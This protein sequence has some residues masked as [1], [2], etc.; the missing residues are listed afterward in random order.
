[1]SIQDQLVNLAN[2]MRI[3]LIGSGTPETLEPLR[4]RV[5]PDLPE[6]QLDQILEYDLDLEATL[7]PLT[8]VSK[9]VRFNDQ[10]P[11]L[12]DA[13][14]KTFADLGDD[15]NV[16][17]GIPISTPITGG[18]L[19]TDG[20]P[21]V[22]AQL[23][24]MLAKLSGKIPILSS[25]KLPVA[26][27]VKWF[28]AENADGTGPLTPGQDYL[29]PEGLDG[30]SA[31]ILFLPKLSDQPAA[32]VSRWLFAKVKL[33]AGAFSLPED[34]PEIRLPGIEVKVPNLPLTPLLA[35]RF[36]IQVPVPTLAPAE[37]A[38]PEL[39]ETQV[40]NTFTRLQ[41]LLPDLK[42][43]LEYTLTKGNAA[44]ATG[45]VVDA[46]GNDF[47]ASGAWTPGTLLK[48]F[49][50]PQI[51][52][53][54]ET[55]SPTEWS[56]A[57][58]AKVT[59]LPGTTGEI[60]VPLPAV[61][62]AQ[63]PVSLP[64]L[65]AGFSER[66]WEGDEAI[67][68]VHYQNPLFQGTLDR[69][70]AGAVDQVKSA[71]LTPLETALKLLQL[72]SLLFPNLL[73]ASL[74]IGGQIGHLRSFVQKL[75]ERAP[76]NLVLT[77]EQKHDDLGKFDP[78][79][80]DRISSVFMIGA[81]GGPTLKLFEGKAQQSHELHL[82]M[83]PGFVAASYWTIHESAFEDLNEPFDSSPTLPDPGREQEGRSADYPHGSFGNMAKSFRWDD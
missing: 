36:K 1:M 75:R 56:L 63:L 79:W 41:A 66:W 64:V 9:N 46:S 48:F 77:A 22:I 3:E 42:V 25:T 55:P 21:A 17:G 60:P 30:R 15:E 11:E 8:T 14:R 74:P 80:Y 82:R 45:D 72:L 47:P 71:L 38:V 58:K 51:E 67:L 32:A 35:E 37:A 81:P 29:A 7:D 61:R 70:N 62:L 43:S 57:L 31:S 34:K 5:G 27:Q 4:A 12:P 33:S 2:S 73:G 24:G 16:T 52:P 6:L 20:V 13:D 26:L 10:F 44:P 83:P 19:R 49:L 69:R 28:V 68:F 54:R 40:Q 53:L 39:V 65:V 50:R 59:G 78:G 23:S 76:T 18:F